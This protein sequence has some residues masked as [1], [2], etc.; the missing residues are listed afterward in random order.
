MNRSGDTGAAINQTSQNPPFGS[1]TDPTEEE[2]LGTTKNAEG[3]DGA[4]VEWDNTDDEA[5]HLFVYILTS[6][7]R[8]IYHL[9]QLI[10]EF[11]TFR[12]LQ[13]SFTH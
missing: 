3:E 4:L 1:D 10:F 2:P 5:Q 12:R 11:G 9:H 7:V 6:Y 13:S 8:D